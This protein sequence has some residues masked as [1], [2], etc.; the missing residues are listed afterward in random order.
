MD[1]D[2]EA[3]AAL[4]EAHYG[5]VC[6]YVAARGEP[7]LVEDVAAE[8]FLVAWRRRHEVP[9]HA[10][11]W[12]LSTAAKCLANQRRA[13]LRSARLGQRVAALQPG[14]SPSVEEALT[15][16]DQGRALL[17][18]LSSLR[19]E[20]R[21]LLMLHHWDG[22]AAREIAAVAGCSRVVARS[23]LHRAGRRLRAALEREL[24]RD[25]RCPH[26]AEMPSTV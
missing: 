9:G 26:P 6:R 15:R 8:T 24:D 14:I 2:A 17:A 23:R 7:D 3:F 1:R 12:L 20:D 16:S 21:E 25:P 10:R 11:A 5:A 4:F 22:L 13:R 18:A 19:D